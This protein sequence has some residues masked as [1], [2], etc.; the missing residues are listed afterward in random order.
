MI[1]RG[2]DYLYNQSKIIKL[3]TS[4]TK[5]RIEQCLNTRS[6]QKKI[7]TSY[8]DNEIYKRK[9]NLIPNTKIYLGAG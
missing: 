4:R 7:A 2:H 5:K 6:T 8:S 3:L 1:C 9:K